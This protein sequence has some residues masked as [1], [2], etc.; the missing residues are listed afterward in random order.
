MLEILIGFVI[1]GYVCYKIGKNK[2]L[3]DFTIASGVVWV[4]KLMQMGFT[5]R[6]CELIIVDIQKFLEEYEVVIKSKTGK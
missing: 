2:N 6:Q 3:L 5:K 1:W 4:M